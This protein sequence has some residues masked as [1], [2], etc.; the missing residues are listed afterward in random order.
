MISKPITT[1]LVA[2]V[3]F[4]NG[5]DAQDTK[6]NA[7]FKLAV[8]LYNSGMYDLAADQFN[9][10]INAYA[11]TAN[12]IE[13]RFYLGL[14]Q[15]RLKRFEEARMTFQNFA[16]AYTDNPKAPEA[17][18]RVGDAYAA[19]NNDREAA[20]AY[21]RVKVFHPKSSLAPESLLKAALFYR[22]AGAKENA[23]KALRTIIQDYP[24]SSSI[25]EAR[26]GTGELHAEEGRIELAQSEFNRVIQ[27][28]DHPSLKARATLLLG[29]L[30]DAKGRSEEAERL[31]NRVVSNYRSTTSYAAAALELGRLLQLSGK[32][33]E[34][35]DR[36]TKAFDD[37]SAEPSVRRDALAELGASYRN[38]QDF[39]K[40]LS[41]YERF[42]SAFPADESVPAIQFKAGEAATASGDH[43][44]ALTYFRKVLNARADDTWKRKAYVSGAES[45]IKLKD[46][47]GATSLYLAYLDR[48]PSNPASPEIL[49]RLGDIYERRLNDFRRA[50]NSYEDV[51]VKY[52][53][54]SQADDALFAMGRCRQTLDDVAGALSSYEEL[55]EG[56]PSSEHALPSKGRIEFLKNH[57]AKN[58]DQ[59]LEKLAM[60]IGEMVTEKSRAQ[61]AFKL[62]EIYFQDLKD[63]RSAAAQFSNAIDAGLDEK[64]FVDAY[65]YRARCYHLL[66][67]LEPQAESQAIVYY[68]A[69]VKQFPTSTRSD[70]AAFYSMEIKTRGK[71]DAEIASLATH[72][73]ANRPASPRRDEVL[74]MLAS[75]S[76]RLGN[77]REAAR[78]F[79]ELVRNVPNSPFAEDAWLRLGKIYSRLN[80]PDSALFALNTAV[81]RFARGR[82]AAESR[83]LLAG[84][85]MDQHK[86][87]EGVDLHRRIIADHFYTDFASRAA[88]ALGDALLEA[89]E[90]GDAVAQFQ[91]VWDLQQ[92]SP[93]QTPSDDMLLFKLA[94]AFNRK[95]DKQK[96]AELYRTYLQHDRKSVTAGDAY[97]A[98]GVIAR[99]RKEPEAATTYF[100]QAA[101]T[102]AGGKSTREIAD[103][104][105][106]TEQYAD[107]AKQYALLAKTAESTSDREFCLLRI[108]ICK[109]RQHDWKSAQPLIADF[110]K[111]Y[112]N[113]ESSLAEVE[114]EKGLYYYR[115]QDY[116]NAKKTLENVAD[117]YHKTRFAA[118]AEFFL[119]KILEAGNKTQGAIKKYESI[120]KNFP[121][122]D[123]IARVYL[124]L[125][126][127]N[128]NAEKYQDAVTL[129]QKIVESPETAGDILVYAM[130]NLVDAYEAMRLYDAALKVTRDFIERFPSDSSV[131]D[132]LISIGV[133]HTRLGYY[134][135]AIVHFQNL[136]NEAGSDL[137]PEIHYDIGE[138]YYSKG[139]YQQAILEFLKVP[140]LVTKQGGLE[141]TA[142]S[143]Y[144]AGQSYE[145]MS[146]FDQAISMYQQIIDR[147]GIDGTFKAA[148]KKEIDRVR[149]VTRKGSR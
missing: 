149:S 17:W 139:D 116:V 14:T 99:D 74:L 125:G 65:F 29:K 114:Y 45:A 5:L 111:T 146:K 49:M 61:M 86:P 20:S 40:A 104:F 72:Y 136:L 21:E 23:R 34:A 16:L 31:F 142:T 128:F 69:F 130:E 71:P 6:E 30:F 119:G 144:M 38:L 48:Y 43:Q 105:Y 64:Q 18:L 63:Y 98:L 89:G 39:K 41:S 109:L 44:T 91:S 126:N 53:R 25:H 85:M 24:T 46:Y 32:D 19:M 73:L 95:G 54:A 92:S 3:L 113:S 27:S 80:L 60:L 112:K 35:V 120:L 50:A 12:S 77:L 107:A 26:L 36:F 124:S 47:V 15:V 66:A 79:N 75:S 93:F 42:L 140:Y 102:N 100:K 135:Q 57:R 84:M 7:E 78:M 143:L 8:N 137:E 76:E 117:D 11:G 115:Q 118:W 82:H 9:N 129:Y 132:K 122:S 138:A 52:P 88:V 56:Y 134:D 106:Q 127:I 131:M 68:D 58:R 141:W 51:F 4:T 67:D 62:G 103:L 28:A 133:L 121:T 110:S 1:F 70:D 83:W 108:I 59:G 22:R 37:S 90:V 147:P 87:N 13:A 97:F 148:A 81:T 145:K 94:T 96:A 123:V 10:F 101:A 33:A 2:I 55:V